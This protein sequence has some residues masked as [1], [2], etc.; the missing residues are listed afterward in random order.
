[1]RARSAMA[2]QRLGKNPKA[3]LSR[4]RRRSRGPVSMRRR[5]LVKS[6]HAV[7]ERAVAADGV[8]AAVAAALQALRPARPNNRL[9]AQS[10]PLRAAPRP[11]A[12]L[13]RKALPRRTIMSLAPSILSRRATRRA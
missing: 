1:A 7:S 13:D 11:M 12:A 4:R 6:R 3:A 9:R 5:P 8:V 10:L 2:R